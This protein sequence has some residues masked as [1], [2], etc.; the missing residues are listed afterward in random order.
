MDALLVSMSRASHDAQI[1]TN[2]A[3]TLAERL[4]HDVSK[5]SALDTG[6]V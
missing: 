1:F 4:R 6:K 3:S 2:N 5:A